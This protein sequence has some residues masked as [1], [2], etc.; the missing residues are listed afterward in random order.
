[1]ITL[2]TM[3]RW[4]DTH[5]SH[6]IKFVRQRWPLQETHD[7]EGFPLPEAAGIKDPMIMTSLHCLDCRR[8]IRVSVDNDLGQDI[9]K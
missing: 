9:T 4:L 8:G 3:N 6:Q 1:M 2:E 5:K 7:V